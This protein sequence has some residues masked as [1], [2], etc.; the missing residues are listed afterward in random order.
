MRMQRLAIVATSWLSVCAIAPV[1][2]AASVSTIQTA[3][4]KASQQSTA[5][6][7]S[8]WDRAAAKAAATVR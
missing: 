8:E 7:G 5:D 6:H 3:P 1:A 4:E 2:I